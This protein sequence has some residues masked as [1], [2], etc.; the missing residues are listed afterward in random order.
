MADSCMYFI[1]NLTKSG[2]WVPRA[3]CQ[4][5]V[6]ALISNLCSV[7]TMLQAVTCMQISYRCYSATWH[8]KRSTGQWTIL[9][10]EIQFNDLI[11]QCTYLQLLTSWRAQFSPTHPT[12]TLD[13]LCITLHKHS[14]QEGSFQALFYRLD[15]FS[16]VVGALP[17][18]IVRV[19]MW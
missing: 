4:A 13:P 7:V 12:F 18:Q 5:K 17:G 9:F 6:A 1:W 11:T 16:S 14:D 8:I 15:L 2:K 10:T 3:H 19:I